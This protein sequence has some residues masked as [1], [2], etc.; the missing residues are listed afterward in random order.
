LHPHQ[1]CAT[2]FEAKTGAARVTKKTEKLPD[3]EKSLAEISQLIEK[4]EQGEL[5]LDQS[6]GHFERGIT[7]VKHCQNILETA[8]Q[9]VQILIQNNKQ[10]AL[11]DY[12][13]DEE[14]TNEDDGDA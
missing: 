4:M 11:A 5:T 13:N 10:E 6:L 8:E 3:L 14:D 7:L 9:K 1:I 12:G 2:F